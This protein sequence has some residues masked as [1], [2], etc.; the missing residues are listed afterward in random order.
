[1]VKQEFDS[2]FEIILFFSSGSFTIILSRQLMGSSNCL[3]KCKFA[4]LLNRKTMILTQMMADLEFT[5]EDVDCLADTK[6]MLGSKDIT[7]CT[8]VCINLHVL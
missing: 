6:C 4:L 8:S 2:R 7:N 1:M 5:P 3:S